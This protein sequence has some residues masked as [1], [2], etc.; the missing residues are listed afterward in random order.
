MKGVEGDNIKMNLRDISFEG[1][2]GWNW[3]WALPVVGPGT[4][5]VDPSCACVTVFLVL[6]SD[7]AYSSQ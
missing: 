6:L 2:G 4:S 5:N 7:R 1:E 3:H